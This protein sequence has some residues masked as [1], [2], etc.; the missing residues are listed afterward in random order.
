[1]QD[2]GTPDLA[3]LSLVSV[4]GPGNGGVVQSTGCS[5]ERR[6][7]APKSAKDKYLSSVR[8]DESVLWVGQMW[9]EIKK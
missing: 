1:M 7:V 8:K 6:C 5:T 4:T 9:V 3:S 2:G